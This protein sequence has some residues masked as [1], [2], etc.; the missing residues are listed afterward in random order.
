[1]EDN[2]NNGN[3]PAPLQMDLKPE[4]AAGVYSNLALISHS[5][6]DFVLDFARILPGMPKPEV[7]SRIILA[8]EHAKRLLGALQE[9]IHKYEQEFGKIDVPGQGQRTIAPFGNHKGEA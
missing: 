2:N 3:Q 5:H 1:M 7:C 9:N 6:S 4:I 8:P